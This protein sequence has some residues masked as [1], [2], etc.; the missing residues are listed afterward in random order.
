MYGFSKSFGEEKL[1]FLLLGLLCFL[2]LIHESTFQAPI[3]FLLQAYIARK[4]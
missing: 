2:W 1:F 4:K 3:T